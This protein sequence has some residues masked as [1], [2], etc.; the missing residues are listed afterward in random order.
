MTAPLAFASLL[1][2]FFTD[3]LVRQQHAS[4]HTIAS[5]RDAFRLLLRFAEALL[6]ETQEEAK[7]IAIRRDGMRTR[8]LLADEA[9]S[10][11]AL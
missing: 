5:Y 8:A 2:R 9:L 10:K 3:R 4:P 11:E 7:R 6:C 1:Q